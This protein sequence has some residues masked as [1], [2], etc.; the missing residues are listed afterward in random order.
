MAS[1]LPVVGS[2]IDGYRAVVTD[3]REGLLVP[4]RNERALADS[5]CRILDNRALAA[6]MGQLGRES[7]ALYAWERVAEQVLDFYL[8]TG[9]RASAPYSATVAA[10]GAYG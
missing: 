9:T 1:G 6:Q 2:D 5:V 10:L 7:A 4:P 8:R 3:G